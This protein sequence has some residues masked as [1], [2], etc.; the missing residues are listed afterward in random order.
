[1]L[2]TAS[3]V[4]AEDEVS[5]QSRD[6]RRYLARK[7]LLATG[8]VD[9]LPQLDGLDELYGSSVH[10]CPIC[11][12]YE[13]RDKRIA[14]YGK[15]C[16][17]FGLVQEMTAWSRDLLLLTDG[18]CDFDA[19]QISYLNSMR[20]IVKQE[21]VT[22]LEGEGEKLRAVHFEDGTRIE[23]DALFFSTGQ[24]LHTRELPVRLGCQIT[25]KESVW[26]GDF[27]MTCV[28]GIYC[29]GDAS[30]NA[31]LVIVAAA[32]GAV[33]AVAINKALTMEYKEA[34]REL[35]EAK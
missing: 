28:E 17:G 23:R 13:W 7:V 26:V 19:G 27:E 18:P 20:I 29:C 9:E 10:H 6:G 33:A 4:G 16:T 21:R 15:N 1:M 24:S 12:G 2:R 14:V 32:E 30:R 22:R 8:V 11:D 31:Q 25:E 35:H 34:K 3:V 5:P